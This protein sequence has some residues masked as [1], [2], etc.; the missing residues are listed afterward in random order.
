MKTALKVH[1]FHQS[2]HAQELHPLAVFADNRAIIT[3]TKHDPWR[4][5][6]ALHGQT[7]DVF[8]FV[9][10]A[11]SDRQYKEEHDRE[12]YLSSSYELFA[13]RARTDN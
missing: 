13:T 7:A 5:R 3:Q 8:Q 2:I 10:I 11:N 1:C 6:L 4:R 9:H 12:Q